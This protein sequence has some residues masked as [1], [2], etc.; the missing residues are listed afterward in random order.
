MRAACPA[1]WAEAQC[2]L[3]KEAMGIKA[4]A[5][6]PT[7]IGSARCYRKALAALNSAL[8]VWTPAAFAR[9][10]AACMKVRMRVDGECPFLPPSLT[11]VNAQPAAP[12]SASEATATATAPSFVKRRGET[13]G[14]DA[15][16]RR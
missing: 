13:N 1:D 3:G 12:P 8:E 7:A 6:P 14:V 9:D 11:P 2:N 15:G 10:H 4:K 16:K 5:M